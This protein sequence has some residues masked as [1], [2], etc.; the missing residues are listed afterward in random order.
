[1]KSSPLER[2]CEKREFRLIL[3]SPLSNP[4]YRPDI[5]GLRGVAVLMVLLF[6]CGFDAVQGG[7]IGVDIFFVISGYLITSLILSDLQNGTFN[8][9]KFYARRARRLVP[10]MLATIFIT[11]LGS[12]LIMAPE[13]LIDTAKS[14]A[15]AILS[16]S[17]FYFAMVTRYFDASAHAKPLLH[18]WSLGVE[19]QYYLFWPAMLWLLYRYGGKRAIAFIVFSGIPVGLALSEFWLHINPS[20]TYFL[21]PFRIFQFL[22]GAA[23]V[24][25][26]RIQIPSRLAS[27]AIY[28]LALA[29]C[30]GTACIYSETT[31]FPGVA[32][33]LPSGATALLIWLGDR[34]SIHRILANPPLV[35]LGKISYSTYLIHWPIVVCYFYL[36]VDSLSVSEKCTL[37]ALCLASGQTLYWL[38]EQPFR[39]S[40]AEAGV[41]CPKFIVGMAGAVSVV[42]VVC[43]IP[44]VTAGMPERINL[45]PEVAEYRRQT[46]FHFLRDYTNGVLS[47]GPEN[48]KRVLIFGDSIMQNYVPAILQIDGFRSARVEIVSRGGCVLARDAVLINSHSPDK[49]CIELRERLYSLKGPYDTVVWGQYWNGYTSNLFWQSD[50]VGPLRA[51]P[52]GYRVEGWASGIKETI[53][54]FRKISRQIVVIG[55]AVAVSEV[56]PVLTRIGPLTNITAIPRSFSAMQL[57]SIAQMDSTRTTIRTLVSNNE[58]GL[59]IEPA[60]IICPNGYC[61]LWCDKYSY[62]LDELHN[63]AAATPLLRQGLEQQGLQ[64]ARRETGPAVPRTAA[65]SLR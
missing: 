26:V 53:E 19:E 64:L 62:F 65:H 8:F 2:A 16:A 57:S 60:Q 51:F 35:W 52:S 9:Y 21:L 6:H 25:L 54:H 58:H 5:D 22:L 43:S 39:H 36:S 45:V 18:T 14:G 37:L 59:Y 24:W 56:N 48:G 49:E 3:R 44:L 12:A 55:P 13:H 38:V 20:H 50:N 10:A 41:R 31:P 32:A 63:T 7:F 40:R 33:M 1:V 34:Y 46:Q 23:C 28:L 47:L 29:T 4:S 42:A 30:I 11:M 15:L 27:A 61:Q 17:N